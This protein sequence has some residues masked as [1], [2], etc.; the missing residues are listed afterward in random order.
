MIEDDRL[1]E[2]QTMEQMPKKKSVLNQELKR[3]KKK[4]VLNQE[5]KRKKKK[6]VLNQ[7]RCEPIR[8]RY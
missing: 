4:S 1:M 7:E 3:K 6:S 8:K 5:L 2:S